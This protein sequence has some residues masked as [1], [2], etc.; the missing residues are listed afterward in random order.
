MV[1]I[2]FLMAEVKAAYIMQPLHM[3]LKRELKIHTSEPGIKFYSGNLL[4]G[5]ISD[6]NEILFTRPT[7]FCL[8][9]QHYPD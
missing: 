9:T 2:L 4:D 6:K 7:G 1:T 8:E 3:K 5:S